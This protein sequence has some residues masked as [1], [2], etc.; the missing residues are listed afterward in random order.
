MEGLSATLTTIGSVITFLTA[1]FTNI[2]KLVVS[3]PAL[4]IPFSVFVLGAIIG[5]TSRLMRQA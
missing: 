2:L 5:L 1:Q 3:E 4:L